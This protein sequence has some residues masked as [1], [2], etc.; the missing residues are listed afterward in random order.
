[1]PGGVVKPMPEN[2]RKALG[3]IVPNVDIDELFFHSSQYQ[4]ESE[5]IAEPPAETRAAL[6]AITEKAVVLSRDIRLLKE[7]SR[8]AI[9]DWH[10]LDATVAQLSI[11]TNAAKVGYNS[12]APTRGR[13]KSH[14]QSFVRGLARLFES[15]GYKA[16]AR[17]NGELVAVVSELLSLYDDKPADVPALVRNALR[18]K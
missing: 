18:K 3:R 2:V 12:I 1:M 9:G 8:D 14:R 5:H 4:L 7:E 15:A 13:T 16:D 10:L 6:D 11:L 17:P